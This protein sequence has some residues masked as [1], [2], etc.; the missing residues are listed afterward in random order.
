MSC[1]RFLRPASASLFAAGLVGALLVG[2]AAAQTSFLSW[3]G[4]TTNDSFGY[5][6]AGAGDVNGDGF[7]D[8]VIG[9]RDDDPAGIAGAGSAYVQSGKDG[10]LIWALH[11]TQVGEAFGTSV[12]GVADLNHDG[13][14]DFAVGAPGW[15]NAVMLMDVGAVHVF[16]GKTG[17]KFFT[18][19]GTQTG[20]LYGASVDGCGDWNNDGT[21]DIVVGLPNYDETIAAVLHPNTGRAV[22]ISGTVPSSIMATFNGVD[23]GENFGWSV[24]GVGDWDADGVQ[25]IVVGSPFSPTSVTLGGK[26]RVYSGKLKS[27]LFTAQGSVAGGSLGIGVGGAGDV[28][29]DG[30]DDIVVGAY[31]EAG[32][33]G[34]VRV[35][36]GNTGV[37]SWIKPGEAANDR[38]GY[39]VDGVGDADKDGFD[40]F[41]AGAYVAAGA[42]YVKVWSGKT[43]ALLYT[44]ILAPAGSEQFGASVAGAG[45]LD[46]DGWQ[47]LVI[48][49]YAFDGPA[50]VDAGRAW[51][52]D[53]V[54]HQANLGF[55]GP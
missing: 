14:A 46:Q 4:D 52:Y 5:A 32:N 36:L 54:V 17:T 43:G 40:D 21:P 55:A 48:G 41:A 25:D 22:V 51:A 24:A 8:V 19:G 42:G 18:F 44:K 7:P 29:N 34:A 9:A 1:T 53:I 20:D 11:G 23:N 37:A 35:F 27:L 26:A 50:G 31:G 10:T 16:N 12:A 39:D 28:N 45:D 3:N 49:D 15:D 47:D 30:K 38:L 33:A 2:S 13:F 6:V